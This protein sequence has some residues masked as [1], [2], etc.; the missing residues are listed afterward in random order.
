MMDDLEREL[1]AAL[2]RRQPS[3]DFAERVVAR[4][5]AAPASVLAMP[6]RHPRPPWRSAWV[7]SIAAGLAA[8]T[9]GFYQYREYQ[10]QEN[11][12]G[13]EAKQQLMLAL[14]ITAEKLH[15]AQD[16]VNRSVNQRNQ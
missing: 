8:V 13:V 16:S 3:V 6:A 4:L 14:E 1:R 15:V 10:Y 9:F 12:R 11:Q 5:P 7:G 2:E